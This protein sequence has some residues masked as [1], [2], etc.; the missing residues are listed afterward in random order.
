MNAL[1]QKVRRGNKIGVKN[2]NEFALGCFQTLGQGASFKAL[3]IIAVQVFDGMSQ[4]GIA[5]DQDAR[6]LDGFVG[7]V[8]EQL[9]IELVLRIVEPADSVEEPIDNVLLVIDR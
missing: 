6:D 8:V 2:G 9:D 5:I 3:P 4:G 7:R 1:H